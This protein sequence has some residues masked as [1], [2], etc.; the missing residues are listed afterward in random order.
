MKIIIDSN[1]LFSA[2]IK[3]STTR[4]L[5]IEYNGYFLFPNYVFKELNKYKQELL[6]KSKMQ[7]EE[8]NKL[9]QIILEKVI[10]IS[11]EDIRHYR[12]EAWELIKDIAPEDVIFIAVG[13]AYQN[14]IL[15]SNDKNLKSQNRVKVLN[16]KEI[17]KILK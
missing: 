7:E 3:D 13:L 6:L 17:I 10:V 5:I 9:L 16:T 14:S 12:K 15:W 1:I 8:F 4:R 11:N 2:L